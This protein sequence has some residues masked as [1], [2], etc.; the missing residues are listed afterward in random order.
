[1]SQCVLFEI[2]RIEGEKIPNTV[3]LEK[4]H[5]PCDDY[6]S[7]YDIRDLQTYYPIYDVLFPGQDNS[8]IGLNHYYRAID[9]LRVCKTGMTD[10]TRQ[11]RV[12]IKYAP[13]LDP[14]KYM[15]GKYD[16]CVEAQKRLPTSAVGKSSNVVDTKGSKYDD[17]NNFSYVDAFFCYLSS[18]L[19]TEYG[20]VHGVE[21]YGTCLG[22]Q[23]RFR[24]NITDELSYLNDSDEFFEKLKGGTIECDDFRSYY[25]SGEEDGIIT[26]NTRGNKRRLLLDD[27][28]VE[29]ESWLDDI[30]VISKD[31]ADTDS[32]LP[33]LDNSTLENAFIKQGEELFIKQ[34]HA[35]EPEDE[36]KK[37][38]DLDIELVYE[39]V[40]EK[41][42]DESDQ[43]DRSSDSCIYYT[44]ED[45]KEKSENSGKK[46]RRVPRLSPDSSKSKDVSEKEDS[47]SEW[48]DISEETGDDSSNSDDD[49]DNSEEMDDTF[50][51]LRDFPTQL[52]FQE[53]CDG[54]LD[55][56]FDD[57]KMNCEMAMAAMFQIVVT[58]SL[59][60]SV[61]GFT[62]NDLHTNNIMYVETEVETLYYK[63]A[64]KRYAVPTYGRI[65]KIIDFGRAIYRVGDRLF[66]SD[67]FDKDG[68]AHTQYNCEPY[69]NPKK[70]CIEPNYSFDLC[71]LA[72][73][74]YDFVLDEDYLTKD[75]EGKD[76]R[77]SMDRFQRLIFLWCQDDEERSVLYKSN[78]DER[79][80]GFSLYKMIARTV[81]RHVPL[82]QLTYFTEFL[83]PETLVVEDSTIPV[84]ESLQDDAHLPWIDIDSFQKI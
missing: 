46:Q 19:K 12:H 53:K 74:I 75:A 29:E 42:V 76:K 23:Q 66:T 11:E 1:M 17:P 25:G 80:K 70:P 64:G 13:L 5:H 43:D 58:L 65:M 8:A 36:I 72:T 57:N 37:F 82:D 71:R 30:I 35:F 48:E 55:S 32:C 67:C 18:Q 2:K 7:Q 26:G 10:E 81:H 34:E 24:V 39:K 50:A 9:L 15:I 63:I 56:L 68:D 47:E 31:L 44:D 79:Y 73:S 52:I 40:L 51:Y 4:T 84:G 60:Q 38:E 27:I 62:H 3:A 77:E 45:D 54:T 83:M 59:Y 22:I 49:D 6:Y 20:F 41:G 61:F 28:P 78:G 14:I 16:R 69:Y 21:F 33:V